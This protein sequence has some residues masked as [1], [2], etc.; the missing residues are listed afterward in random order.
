M[1][2][3]AQRL[4]AVAVDSHLLHSVGPLFEIV[5]QS[6]RSNL[7]EALRRRSQM[8]AVFEERSLLAFED[9]R[10]CLFCW[11]RDLWAEVSSRNLPPRLAVRLLVRAHAVC[12]Q[13]EECSRP[14]CHPCKVRRRSLQFHSQAKLRAQNSVELP[15]VA[16]VAERQAPL[17]LFVRD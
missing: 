4:T 1:R 8:A 14:I 9:S 13:Q 6:L 2:H 12:S 16:V 17:R 5:R 7:V 11:L 10:V 3:Q 15:S